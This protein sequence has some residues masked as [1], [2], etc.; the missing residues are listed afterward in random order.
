MSDRFRSCCSVLQIKGAEGLWGG[1]GGGCGY[2]DV[3]LK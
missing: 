3:M 2:T 1:G